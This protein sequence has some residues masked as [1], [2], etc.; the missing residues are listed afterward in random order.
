MKKYN[1]VCPEEMEWPRA[2]A[3][4]LVLEIFLL[5]HPVRPL[6]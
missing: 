3:V 1:T 5:A 4:S 2:E 6:T